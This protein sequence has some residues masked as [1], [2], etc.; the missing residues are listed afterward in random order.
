VLSPT[1]ALLLSD[2][3]VFG[4][5]LRQFSPAFGL[6]RSRLR[7]F[8]PAFG[9]FRSRL[10]QLCPS[11]G[12]LGARFRLFGPGFRLFKPPPVFGDNRILGCFMRLAP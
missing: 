12:L 11:L 3:G 10:R 5:C 6:F 1:L 7:Q 2:F 8:R 4:A 9:L